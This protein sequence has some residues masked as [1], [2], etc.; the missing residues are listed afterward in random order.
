[1]SFGQAGS[2]TRCSMRGRGRRLPRRRGAGPHR[3]DGKPLRLARRRHVALRRDARLAGRADLRRLAL[4][5]LRGRPRHV[6]N[7]PEFRAAL[8]PTRG[9]YRYPT[10]SARYGYNAADLRQLRV[11]AERRGP[12]PRRLPADD[13][14]GRRGRRH[15]RDRHRPRPRGRRL[16]R[17][18]GHRHA[19]RRPL[20]HL[21][22]HRRLDHRPARAPRARSATRP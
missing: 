17:R 3:A 15:G 2:R 18:R 10:N 6:S 7:P 5:R 8:A 16:A 14:G 22:G 9:D 12:A 1:M 13:E 21:L 19:R 20:H 11:S 4:R